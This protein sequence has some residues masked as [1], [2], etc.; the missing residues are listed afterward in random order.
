VN[1]LVVADALGVQAGALDHLA[2]GMLEVDVVLEKVR[3]PV[4]MGNDQ[5]V[6]DHVV[7]IEQERLGGVS[8]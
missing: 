1:H 7:D 5:L 4:H 2:V 6:R 8:S 3:V